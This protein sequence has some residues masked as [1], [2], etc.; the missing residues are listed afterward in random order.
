MKTIYC[1]HPET[2]ELLYVDAVFDTELEPDVFYMPENATYVEPPEYHVH[3][4]PVFNEETEEWHIEKDYRGLWIYK[5]IEEQVQMVT[6]GDIPEGWTFDAPT[7]ADIVPEWELEPKK[8]IRRDLVDALTI[9]Y[10]GHIFRAD[11]ESQDDMARLITAYKES[12][13][14]SEEFEWITDDKDIVTMTVSKLAEVLYLAVKETTR[15]KVK[16]YQ[17]EE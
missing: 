6:L 12:G 8:Q 5:G 3:E 10:E 9:E 14:E 11:Q 1:Y 17:D 13:H 7:A 2:K 4:I 15:I 16:V